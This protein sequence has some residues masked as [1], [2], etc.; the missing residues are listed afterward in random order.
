MAAQQ[1][2][3]PDQSVPGRAACKATARAGRLPGQVPVPARAGVGVLPGFQSVLMAILAW[4]RKWMAP[5]SYLVFGVVIA[6][7][8]WRTGE[9]LHWKRMSELRTESPA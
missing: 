4:E 2:L 6:W 8:L 5:L 7:P 3:P 9:S 1:N